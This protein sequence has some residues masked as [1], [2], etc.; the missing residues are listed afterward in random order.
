M[1]KKNRSNKKKSGQKSSTVPAEPGGEFVQEDAARPNYFW[2][3]S[4]GKHVSMMALPLSMI[5]DAKNRTEDPL[6]DYEP[7][8]SDPCPICLLP[9]PLEFGD[10]YY[11]G[12]C[13]NVICWG[14]V[15]DKMKVTMRPKPNE[16]REENEKKNRME[17]VLKG[18]HDCPF[19]R[20]NYYHDMAQGDRV[21]R[22]I[23]HAESGSSMAMYLIGLFHEHGEDGV[24]MNIPK[25]LEWYQKAA[26]AGHGF[27]NHKL[28]KFYFWGRRG[29]K[30]DKEAALEYFEKSAAF[31]N[32]PAFTDLADAQVELGLFEEALLNTRKALMCGS[33]SYIV[34]DNLKMH[35]QSGLLRKEE[36]AH[37]LRVHQESIAK[38]YS[39]SREEAIEVY[40]LRKDKAVLK[41]EAA[42]SGLFGK[43]ICDFY[44]V[45]LP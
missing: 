40:S 5:Q 34:V 44:G 22:I 7:P 18:L 24:D 3:P 45:K 19:C 8:E 42:E 9:L 37:S 28:G 23:R 14:C 27:A 2:D 21:E 1:G 20:Q 16:S 6:K 15:L 36:Y 11:F 41:K 10:S 32:L 43:S 33:T 29:V 4:R 26:D 17:N 39:K 25:A 31:G 35:Y 13:S 12:C 30:L 38:R